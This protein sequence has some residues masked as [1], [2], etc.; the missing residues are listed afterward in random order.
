M[1]TTKIDYSVAHNILNEKTFN[2][3][4]LI[5][6]DNIISTPYGLS[7]LEIQG[8]LNLPQSFPQANENHK[9]EYLENFARVNDVYEAVKFGRLEFDPK[10]QS[11]VTLYIG[12]SQRL[13]GS[14]VNLETPLAVLR[15]K[16]ETSNDEDTEYGSSEENKDESIKIVDIVKKKIIFKQRPLP[17][18]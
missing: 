9:P 10:N 5:E 11:N 16:T 3:G 18:M 7:I 13:L 4:E 12:K 2:E 8:E 14:M 6:N 17:I 15:I 1:P